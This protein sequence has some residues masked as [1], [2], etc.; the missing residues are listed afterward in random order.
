VLRKRT[1]TAEVRRSPSSTVAQQKLCDQKSFGSLP[2]R[3]IVQSFRAGCQV[4][5]P[6]LDT[7]IWYFT[8]A[9]GGLPEKT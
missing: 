2:R 9:R 4:L 5:P 7:S 8:S 1:R 6:S 3:E